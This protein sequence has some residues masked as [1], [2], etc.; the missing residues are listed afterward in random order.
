M[1]VALNSPDTNL[2]ILTKTRS[3][4]P[5]VSLLAGLGSQ[6]FL[7]NKVGLFV[8]FPLMLLFRRPELDEFVR[9][10]SDQTG[11]PFSYPA[12][13]ATSGKP[14][15]GFIVDHNRVRLGNGEDMFASACRALSAWKIFDVGWVEVFP[16]DAPIVMGSTVAVLAGMF[17][18]W[19][20]N[21]CRIVYTVQEDGPLRRFGFAYGTLPEHAESGEERFIIEWNRGDDSVWYDLL[22]FSRPNQFLAKIAYPVARELQ[23]RFASDSLQ[24]MVRHS[25]LSPVRNS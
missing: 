8:R 3:C 10:I 9:F 2:P 21:A 7:Y 14:P 17:A 25:R 18:L 23:K 5:Q 12:V 11:K 15:A 24:A 16:P 22:A 13:G 4:F 20:L 1:R 19:F 6:C